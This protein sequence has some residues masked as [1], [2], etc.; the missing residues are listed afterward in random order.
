MDQLQS[1]YLTD[2]RCF[3]ASHNCH[4]TLLRYGLFKPTQQGDWRSMARGTD[5]TIP[6]SF[7][8][9]LRAQDCNVTRV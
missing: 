6:E 2:R 3:S 8:R 5:Q 1:E 4:K 7:L 9:V